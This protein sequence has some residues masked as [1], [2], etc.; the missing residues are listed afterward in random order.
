M[1]DMKNLTRLKKL[2]ENAPEATKAAEGEPSKVQ[3][4]LKDCIVDDDTVQ[5]WFTDCAKKQGAK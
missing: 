3:G 1:F 2:D 4:E 5:K